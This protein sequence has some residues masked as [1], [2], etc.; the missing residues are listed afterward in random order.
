M[1]REP[2]AP[3]TTMPGAN[4]TDPRTVS[5]PSPRVVLAVTPISRSEAS[6]VATPKRAKS[7]A[8]RRVRHLFERRSEP[9]LAATR[10]RA[11]KAAEP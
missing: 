9:N 10:K 11:K 3:S 7:A 4:V 8:E 2:V 6:L 1:V 5:T